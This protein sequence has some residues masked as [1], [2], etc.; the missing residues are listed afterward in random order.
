MTEPLSIRY[1]G[2]LWVL[3]SALAYPTAWLLTLSTQPGPLWIFCG[4]VGLLHMAL[5]AV[6]EVVRKRLIVHQKGV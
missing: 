1:P 2:L 6:C 4:S 3:A 5:I